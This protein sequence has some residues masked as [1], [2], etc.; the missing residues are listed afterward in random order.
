MTSHALTLSSV[1]AAS[2]SAA[3][4]PISVE[5]ASAGPGRLVTLP[6]LER[7]IMCHGPGVGLAGI[8]V[9]ISASL[10]RIGLSASAAATVTVR[11]QT[12]GSDVRRMIQ[13][14]G[15]QAAST[16]IMPVVTVLVHFIG[17]LLKLEAP[18]P[19]RPDSVTDMIQVP[20]PSHWHLNS[21]FK[22]FVGTVTESPE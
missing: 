4:G 6:E 3:A 7:I 1:K 13:C 21:Q 2:L 10:T 18:G 8:Q 11:R 19:G 16:M 20:G 15:T 17:K 5:A 14:G 12:V 9:I 22:L